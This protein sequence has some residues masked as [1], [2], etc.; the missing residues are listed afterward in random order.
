MGIGEYFNLNKYAKFFKVGRMSED[1]RDREASENSQGF[2]QEQFDLG[3]TTSNG[4]NYNAD[5]GGYGIQG[6]T[7][8]NIQFDQYFGNKA[9]RIA[10]Y[11]EMSKYPEI[12]D[13]LDNICDDAM[14]ESSNGVML[15][16]DIKEELPAHI[17]D[18][19]RKQWNYLLDDVYNFDNLAW[20]VF[21]KWLVDGELYIE[22]ILNNEGDDI[23]D[24]KILPAHTMAPVY[25]DNNIVGF[26]QTVKPINIDAG[27]NYGT[28]NGNGEDKNIYFDK[29]QIVYINYGDIG[30]NRYDVHGFLESSIRTY[31]Q[32]KN[33]EDAVVI[34]RL[35]R[36][37]ERRI[38]N[39]SVGRMPK[40]RAD[41][42]LRGVMQRYRKRIKYD[43]RTGA[44]DS[45][46]NIQAM[47][48]DFWFPKNADGEGTSVE[49]LGAGQNLGEMQDVEYFLKKLYKTLKLP[50]S[51]WSDVDSGTNMYSQG[52]SGEITR[53]EIQFANFINRLQKKFKPMLLDAFI[54]L[55]RVRGVVD[56]RYIDYALYNIIF[57]EQNEY[58]EYKDLELLESRFALLGSI[59]AYI[60]KPEENE[61]GYFS[62]EFVLRNWFMMT[63]EEYNKNKEMLENE[64]KSAEQKRSDSGFSG[65]GET[66]EGGFG[67]ETGE[68]GFGGGTDVGAGEGEFGAEEPETAGGGGETGT[69]GFQGGGGATPTGEFNVGGAEES[70]KMKNNK[71]NKILNEFIKM[72]KQIIRKKNRGGK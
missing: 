33:L 70:F 61:N 19:I 59:E 8:V 53:E 63:N 18:E 37:P 44:M 52:K 65:G 62:Q 3:M 2:S 64:K 7:S 22:L 24:F 67:G 47:V 56:K 13:A 30:R 36:A 50:S 34:Y 26:V 55:L 5:H 72:D 27:Q 15:Q 46:G 69:G 54:T 21:R 35:V 20:D 57:T 38:W 4:S 1:L 25:E 23:L 17:E 48:E 43:T 32:L 42:Y 16:L 40:T 6:M 49:T 58:K 60:Y 28:P 31:N 14:A 39:I 9:Q 29:D 51:R 41:E 71:D 66:G 45:A 12:T 10:T 68:G 11:R